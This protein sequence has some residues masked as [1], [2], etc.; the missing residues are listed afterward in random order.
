VFAGDGVREA[1]IAIVWGVGLSHA[2]PKIAEA[3]TVGVVEG[4]MCG[5]ERPYRDH[6]IRPEQGV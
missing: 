4:N 2:I 1:Y 3:E 5:N 6:L